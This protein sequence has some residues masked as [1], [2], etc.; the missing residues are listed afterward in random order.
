[1]VADGHATHLSDSAIQYKTTHPPDQRRRLNAGTFREAW[2]VEDS[3]CVP[4]YQMTKMPEPRKMK[5][6]QP[7]EFAKL[8]SSPFEIEPCPA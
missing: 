4:V 3:D 1:L 7:E 2:K 8:V 5:M 6:L